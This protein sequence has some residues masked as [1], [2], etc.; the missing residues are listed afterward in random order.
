M[1]GSQECGQKDAAITQPER[2]V[3]LRR[4]WLERAEYQRCRVCVLQVNPFDP[5]GEA[6]AAAAACVHMCC[7]T[8]PFLPGDLRRGL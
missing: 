5:E 2:L 1:S 8:L 3:F 6:A 4:K 7:M